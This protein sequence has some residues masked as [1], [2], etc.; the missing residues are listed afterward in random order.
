MRFFRIKEL[1]HIWNTGLRN[2]DHP[3]FGEAREEIGKGAVR[4]NMG[5]GEFELLLTRCLNNYDAGG[6]ES[7]FHFDNATCQSRRREHWVIAV[8]VTEGRRLRR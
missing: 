7:V 1:E 6:R 5:A 3:A 2:D 8:D 4:N